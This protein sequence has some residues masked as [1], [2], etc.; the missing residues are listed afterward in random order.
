[1]ERIKKTQL[2]DLIPF[3]RGGEGRLLGMTEPDLCGPFHQ[4]GDV[5]AD[6]TAVEQAVFLGHDV[7]NDG[8]LLVRKTLSEPFDDCHEGFGFFGHCQSFDLP[9][10]ESQQSLLIL[11]AAEEAH[12][13]NP[14]VREVAPHVFG[15]EPSKS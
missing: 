7:L 5:V 2:F 1:M 12:P 4:D 6:G 10:E 11:S 14:W 8:S 9:V 3:R 15:V 13:E